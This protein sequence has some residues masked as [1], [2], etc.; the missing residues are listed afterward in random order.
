MFDEPS[1]RFGVGKARRALDEMTTLVLLGRMN[2]VQL[3]A[4]TAV[5]LIESAR[6]IARTDQLLARR[7]V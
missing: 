3:R 6:L 5:S 2:L 7:L 4:A 1:D